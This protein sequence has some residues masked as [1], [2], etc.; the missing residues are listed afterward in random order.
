MRALVL[1]GC[2]AIVASSGCG[3]SA[4]RRASPNPTR[5]H[6]ATTT[7]CGGA[8][9]LCVV[10]GQAGLSGADGDGGAA[11]AA[12]LNRPAD[13]TLDPAGSF[14]VFDTGTARLRRVAGGTITFLA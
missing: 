5:T 6:T 8:G 3:S 10:A 12:R 13:V 7:P 9:I 14:V 4:T 11:T 2:A 1:F